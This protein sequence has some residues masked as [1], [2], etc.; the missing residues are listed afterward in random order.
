VALSSSQ[1]LRLKSLCLNGG[2]TVHEPSTDDSGGGK[3]CQQATQ[4]C[5]FCSCCLLCSLFR[6]V[7]R[8]LRVGLLSFAQRDPRSHGA[9]G[10]AWYHGHVYGGLRTVYFVVLLMPRLRFIISGSSHLILS[11]TLQVR[12]LARAYRASTRI[13]LRER[14]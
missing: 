8:F 13:S 4:L 2:G 3:I 10:F 7:I 11:C 14:Q 1:D 5:L 6:S 12:S 9:R